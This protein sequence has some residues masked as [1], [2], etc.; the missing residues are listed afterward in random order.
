MQCRENGPTSFVVVRLTAL[1]AVGLNSF[2]AG[3]AVTLPAGRRSALHTVQLRGVHNNLLA[4]TLRI[5]L[6][7]PAPATAC[8]VPGLVVRSHAPALAEDKYFAHTCLTADDAAWTL[9]ITFHGFNT[10]RGAIKN[11]LLRPIARDED[12]TLQL[13]LD[14]SVAYQVRL[15][16]HV[17]GRG[18]R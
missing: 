2:F 4:Y 18:G 1:S 7:A 8:R 16:A 5:A 6:D 3:F 17:V 9:P 13:F 15:H 11:V 10:P 12:L 14:P